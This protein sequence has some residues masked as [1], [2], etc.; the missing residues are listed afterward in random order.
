MAY[1]VINKSGCTERKGNVQL[2][3][4]FY[5]EP[6]DPRYNDK[7]LYLID[8]TSLKYL[9]DYPGKVDVEGNPIDQKDYD[10]WYQSLPRVWQNT[11]FHSHFIYLAS[12]FTEEDTKAQIAFHLPNFYKAF[13]ERQDAVAGGMRHGWATEK[14]IRPTDYSKL[15][16]AAKYDTRV[17][18]CQARINTLTEFSYKPEGGIE[19]KEYPATAIDVGS[20]AIDRNFT[21]SAGTTRFGTDNP[22]NDTGAIDTFEVWSATSMTGTNK[23][24]TFYGSDTDYTNRD[25]VTIGTVTAGAKR[26]FTGLSIDV[27]TGDFAGIYFS[28]GSLERD[29]GVSGNVYY[30]AGDQFG[31]GAQTYA[32]SDTTQM[33]VYGTGETPPVGWSNI[34]HDKGIAAASISH[35]KGIAVA[36]ISHVKGV[37]V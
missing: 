14:R 26:T 22:A 17:A 6:I 18:S 30:K 11:P 20:A 7:Y 16:S 23:V 10:S 35:K 34:S 28:V 3:L 32:F 8:T 29:S 9:T 13:Q 37:A 24:G 21:L 19:G 25:G 27:S 5:L 2:R 1:A 33:S 15:E 12:D 31:A 4:D 36:S